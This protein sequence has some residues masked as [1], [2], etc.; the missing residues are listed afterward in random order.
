MQ[1][2]KKSAIWNLNRW[3][4][5]PRALHNNIHQKSNY[6]LMQAYLCEFREHFGGRAAIQ[7]GNAS[8]YKNSCNSTYT[9][10][11]VK[12]F[13]CFNSCYSLTI[14]NKAISSLGLLVVLHLLLMEIFLIALKHFFF[15]RL[16]K[17][18]RPCCAVL[19]SVS[20]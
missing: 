6:H 19:S 12:N 18:R 9:M 20:S 10:P 7:R 16:R 14:T 3:Y 17:R 15:P 11:F 1:A 2:I 4:F 8:L 5:L 13:M